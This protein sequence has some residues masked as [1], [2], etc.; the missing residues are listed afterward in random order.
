[1]DGVPKIYKN[2]CYGRGTTRRACQCRIK[3]AFDE[4][5]WHAH[6]VITVAAIKCPYGISLL[7]VDCLSRTVFKILPLLNWTWR[8]VTLRTP[9]FLTAKVNLQATCAFL[10]MCKTYLSKIALYLWVIGIT[11]VSD[12]S[13]LQTHSR[14]SAN[15]PFYSPYMNSSCNYSIVTMSVSCTVSQVLSLIS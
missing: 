15:M 14:S 1:M 6:K 2:L 12:K 5:P 13:D 8:P 10:F 3:L 7:F 11:A 4:W 9:L